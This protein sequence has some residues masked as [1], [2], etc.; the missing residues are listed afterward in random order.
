ML[1]TGFLI[2]DVYIQ[3]PGSSIQDRFYYH[4][5]LLVME[6]FGKRKVSN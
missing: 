3:C 4:T 1:D 6:Y 2:L 5:H